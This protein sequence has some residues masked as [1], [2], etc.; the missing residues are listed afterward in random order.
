MYVCMYKGGPKTGP[1]TSTFNDILCFPFQLAP[2]GRTGP[3]IDSA[4]N[5]NDYQES[6]ETKKSGGRVRPARRADNLA[7]IY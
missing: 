7:A 3:G 4:S 6:L 2:S 5:R 1:S